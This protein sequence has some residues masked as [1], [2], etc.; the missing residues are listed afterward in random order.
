MTIGCA[1][2]ELNMDVCALAWY[3]FSTLT[4][5]DTLAFQTAGIPFTVAGALTR[6]RLLPAFL[7]PGHRPH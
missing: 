7:Q 1:R 6:A 3:A 5:T 4:P 2:P